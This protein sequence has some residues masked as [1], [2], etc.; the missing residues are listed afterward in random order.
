MPHSYPDLSPECRFGGIANWLTGFSSTFI[1]S[2]GCYNKACTKTRG[3]TS[4]T[5]KLFNLSGILPKSISL[6]SLPSVWQA[7][8][9]TL[10]IIGSIVESAHAQ[11]TDI[12][13]PVL[14]LDEIDQG[15]LGETQV[16]SARVT[17]DVALKSVTLFH[18]LSGDEAYI[19]SSMNQVGSS[20]VFAVS[21][22]STTDDIRDIEYYLQ[23]EDTGGNKSL[24][25]FAFDPL[26]REMSFESRPAAVPVGKIRKSMSR[27]QRLLWGLAGILIVGV[28]A[29]QGGG[30][31]SGG[32]D[33]PDRI[34]VNITVNPL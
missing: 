30:G 3:V 20:D 25:G 26:I 33:M 8:L 5:S 18:R 15:V 4:V 17:D 12:T 10:L 7:A 2:E 16:F 19:A 27:N 23:V 34:P 11:S 31:G 9:I 28:V 22:P 13:A 14:L 6:R 32:S 29:S 24:S 21:L 1:H